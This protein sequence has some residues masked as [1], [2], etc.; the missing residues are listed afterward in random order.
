[1]MVKELKELQISSERERGPYKK[2]IKRKERKKRR[3]LW[4]FQQLSIKFT[5]FSLKVSGKNIKLSLN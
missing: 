3:R 2:K 1:M 5:S 4:S